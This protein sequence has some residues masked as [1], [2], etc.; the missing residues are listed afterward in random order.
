MALRWQRKCGHCSPHGAFCTLC[1]AQLLLPLLLLLST[2]LFFLAT[3]TSRVV[4]APRR[5]GR[6]DGATQSEHM[7]FIKRRQD[8][9]SSARAHASTGA[10]VTGADV[11]T[12]QHI[13]TCCCL[14]TKRT[15]AQQTSTRSPDRQPTFALR[16]A[17]FFSFFPLP[18]LSFLGCSAS[19][20]CA[21]VAGEWVE[22]GWVGVDE[23]ARLGTSHTHVR[24]ENRRRHVSVVWY[25]PT[26]Y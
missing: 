21:R 12:P 11:I 9:D 4:G 10:D 3:P 6:R 7:F 20:A 17:F 25:Q 14:S 26:T 8:V 24:T 19:L 1:P 23:Q 13:I 5:G 16:S 2:R 15:P 22:T 18:D